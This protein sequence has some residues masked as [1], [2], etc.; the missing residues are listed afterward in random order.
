MTNDTANDSIL[1]RNFT[2]I[3]SIIETAAAA[4]AA[5]GGND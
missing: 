5:D 2:L 1:L 4:A 3:G